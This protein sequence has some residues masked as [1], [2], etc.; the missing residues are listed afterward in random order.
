MRSL[1]AGLAEHSAVVLAIDDL[2][3][4]DDDGLALITELLRPPGAP[5]ILVVG[6]MRPSPEKELRVRGALPDAHVIAL[7]PL[8]ADESR[9]LVLRLWSGG[10]PPDSA[11]VH[12]LAAEAGGH[13]LF[14]TEL[15]E[16][17]RAGR[18]TTEAPERLDDVLWARFATLEESARRLLALSILS[19][20][21]LHP[22]TVA[23]AARL[24]MGEVMREVLGLC[25]A[26]LLKVA[27][28]EASVEPYHNRLREAVSSR[29]TV[30]N[31]RELHERLASALTLREPGQAETIGQHWLLAG[32]DTKAAEYFLIAAESAE[33]AFAFTHA[34]DLYATVLRLRGPSHESSPAIAVAQARALVGAGKSG[35]AGF[36]YASAA[37]LASREDARALR[38]LAADQLLRGG[39]QQGSTR[40]PRRAE[41][42]GLPVPGDPDRRGRRSPRMPRCSV[43]SRPSL[44]RAPRGGDRRVRASQDRPLLGGGRRPKPRRSD[45]WVLLHLSPLSP[46]ASAR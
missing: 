38:R 11:T 7:A 6:T 45:A 39:H 24:E 41:R 42:C 16:R 14:L 35:E 4:A 17:A 30:E 27:S 26:R 12:A 2:Q 15:A 1:F 22:N 25:A 9:E 29:L 5:N 20:V 34:A 31:V 8:L 18:A 10:A 3:W 36:A 23:I 40:D 13:P 44:S 33:R 43:S 19:D 37:K 28:D 32:E 21:P 46:C